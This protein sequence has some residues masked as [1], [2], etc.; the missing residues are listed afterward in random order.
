MTGFELLST[1]IIKRTEAGFLGVLLIYQVIT[2]YLRTHCPFA[3]IMLLEV[4][5][6][7][8]T[9]SQTSGWIKLEFNSIYRSRA[10]PRTSWFQLVLPQ[11]VSI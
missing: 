6:L 9:A 1:G 2:P 11:A 8:M 10:Y 7:Q 5:C 4:G 3:Y